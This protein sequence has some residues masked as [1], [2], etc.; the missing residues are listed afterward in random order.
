MEESNLIGYSM[1]IKNKKQI[2]NRY[3]FTKYL[4]LTTNP[5]DAFQVNIDLSKPE[6]EKNV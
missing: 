1:K 2:C 6:F 4:R 5:I 3:T